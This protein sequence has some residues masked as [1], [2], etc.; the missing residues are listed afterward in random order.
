MEVT[1][2]AEMN[3]GGIS[4]HER[5]YKRI[6]STRWAAVS[7]EGLG[8]AGLSVFLSAALCAVFTQVCEGDPENQF[9]INK[10]QDVGREEGVVIQ[11]E[12]K[13][14]DIWH[15]RPKSARVHFGKNKCESP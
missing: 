10:W 14:L 6:S 15:S 4:A 1:D 12:S 13:I 11:S 7:K 2:S 5:R 8:T 9:Q 3:Q